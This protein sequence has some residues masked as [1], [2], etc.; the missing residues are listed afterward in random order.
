MQPEAVELVVFPAVALMLALVVA[1]PS[2]SRRSLL[3][4]GVVGVAGTALVVVAPSF[5]LALLVVLAIALLHSVISA[6]RNLAARLRLPAL[7]VGLLALAA[8][9]AG[10]AGPE[11][12]ERFGAVGLAAGLAAVIG[13]L[14]YLHTFDAEE[15]AS[16][17]PIAWLAY[18]GPAIAAVVVAAAQ[19]LLQPDAGAAFG[20]SLIG[21]GLLNMV[22]GSVA[23]WA[24]ETTAAAWRYSFAADWGLA[25]CGFGL[26]LVDGE[27]AALIVL[28]SIVLGRLPLYLASREAVREKV[29]TE[30]P[31]NLLVAAALAGSAPF[32]GFS[33]RVLL[34]RGATQLY[35]PLA[36][37]LAL[38]MLLWLPS[39]LR[40]GRSLGVPRGR[41]AVGVAAV[42]VLNV[43]VGL[44]PLP[45]LAA[46][47]L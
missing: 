5:D 15:P 17:S 20:A 47:R 43:A 16:S 26:T 6:K 21:I 42:L 39:S 37:V 3:A 22:W 9:F 12:L 13:V 24:T 1:Q 14:P 27:R 8:V 30:R 33:A 2:A 7:G 18:V 31:I 25:L 19:G 23:A 36:L 34:L 38:A 41:H 28:F 11:T 35:W 10:A 44:Y 40:L 45:L 29:A 46:A 32:A 4:R